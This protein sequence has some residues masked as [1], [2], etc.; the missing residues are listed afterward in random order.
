LE[1]T[2]GIHLRTEKDHT[3]RVKAMLYNRTGGKIKNRNLLP[4]TKQNQALMG[5]S[6]YSSNLT[7]FQSK[8]I[9]GRRKH[10]P[11][12]LQQII[13]NAQYTIKKLIGYEEPGK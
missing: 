2:P 3:S 5:A 12:S 4:P 1:N 10:N 7:G 6:R 11:E 9:F 13:H 8:T